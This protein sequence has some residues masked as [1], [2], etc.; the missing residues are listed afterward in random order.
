MADAPYPEIKKTH[1]MARKGRPWVDYKPPPASPVW[2]VIE[3]FA[4]YHLLLAALDLDVFDTLERIGS[5]M[6]EPVATELGVSTAHLQALLDSLVALGLLEQYRDVYGLNDVARRYLTSDGEASMV[7]LIPVAPGP[8]TNWIGLADTIRNGRPETPID[9]DP[10]AFYVPLVEGTFTTIFRAA[11]R[12]DMFIRYSSL[13]APRVLDLGA[14]GAPW[15]IAVLTA[16][17][18]AT[19]VVNDLSGVLG[20]AQRMTA[21]HGVSDRCEF[22][23]G[24]FHEVELE[25]GSFDLVV[26]GHVCRTEGEDGARHLVERAFAALRPGGRVVVSD[27]FVDPER[28]FNPHAVLMGMTMMASTVNGFPLTGEQVVGWLV[29]T[30]FE[31]IRLIEPIGFQFAYVATRPR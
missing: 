28:K 12:A 15:S 17:P 13:V 27:Y 14:G 23:A 29:G 2:S 7:G 1:S 10:A 21:E 19:A 9:D 3:G 4:S 30:G 20:V 31:A 5:T 26:L 25:E 6:I 11:S 16:C 24:D 18:D 22:L 8:H